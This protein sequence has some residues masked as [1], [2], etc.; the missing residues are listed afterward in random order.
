M[1]TGYRSFTCLHKTFQKSARH[2]RAPALHP[3][4][5][6]VVNSAAVACKERHF[7]LNLNCTMVNH[8]YKLLSQTIAVVIA[9]RCD[10]PKQQL[11]IY[12]YLSSY[13]I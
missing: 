6:R 11:R 2:V 5:R 4:L 12:R 8:Y 7:H 1:V 3:K 9:Q 13:H 10:L